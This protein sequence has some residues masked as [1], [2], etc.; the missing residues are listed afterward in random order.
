MVSS[1]GDIRARLA[2]VLEEIADVAPSDL[3][4]GTNFREDLR[5]D[6]LSIV[7]L[8]VAAEEI[9][10][11]H[12]TNRDIPSLKTLGMAVRCVQHR[13]LERPVVIRNLVA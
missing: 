4:D 1:A 10:D 11:V 13:Q 7:E 3:G 2:D 9:F 6:S 5:M 12:F 8:V